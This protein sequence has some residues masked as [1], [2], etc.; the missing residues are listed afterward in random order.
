MCTSRTAKTYRTNTYKC[1]LCKVLNGATRCINTDQPPSITSTWYV[2]ALTALRIEG[3]LIWHL[4]Y[5]SHA[6][7]VRKVKKLQRAVRKWIS[8]MKRTYPLLAMC[9]LLVRYSQETHQLDSSLIHPTVRSRGGNHQTACNIKK[10]V[11]T[12]NYVFLLQNKIVRYANAV[13]KTC[14]KCCLKM[15]SVCC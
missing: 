8:T 1:F 10:Q 13:T 3:L 6:D 5:F 4:T 2:N 14:H 9:M 7:S 15:E 12:K 11:L